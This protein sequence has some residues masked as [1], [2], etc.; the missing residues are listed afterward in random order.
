MRTRTF[1]ALSLLVPTL[2]VWMMVSACPNE[3][4]AQL[5][6]GG[7]KGGN[8]GR[9]YGGSNLNGRSYSSGTRSHSST[10]GS[11]STSSTRL[12]YRNSQDS[13]PHI[14]T[15]R[16]GLMGA[17]AMNIHDVQFDI[18]SFASRSPAN[19]PFSS[20][21]INAAINTLGT[22]FGLSLETPF[23]EEFGIGLRFLR[24]SHSASLSVF[25]N[26]NMD[27]SLTT[28]AI[29]IMG[30]FKFDHHW[31]GYVGASLA[32]LSEL[33]YSFRTHAADG[34]VTEV[35]QWALVMFSPLFGLGYD[36]PL[37]KDVKPSD[38]RWILTPTLI[39]T[40]GTNNVSTVLAP[41]EHWLVSQVRLGLAV[42]YDL[43]IPDRAA[44]LSTTP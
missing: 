5:S 39:G 15:V 27:F 31:R 19:S 42:Q 44:L 3:A 34:L 21:N 40:I 25:P 14:S 32:F 4:L 12:Y 43:P 30:I 17:L 11:Y 18:T 9:F 36:I 28:M 16:I 6:R 41:N 23:S 35:P 7:Y 29:E 8:I 22:S 33:N 20:G 26:S 10:T 2:A 24:S 37:T 13:I 38:G 1:L